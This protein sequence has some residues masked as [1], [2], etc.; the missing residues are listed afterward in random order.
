MQASS[1]SFD[2]LIGNQ[3]VNWG[4]TDGL[5]HHKQYNAKR[6]SFSLPIG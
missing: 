6:Y 3:L 1:N 4:Q 2:C 5:T